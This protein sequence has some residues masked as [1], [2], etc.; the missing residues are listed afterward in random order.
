MVAESGEEAARKLGAQLQEGVTIDSFE[1]L[2]AANMAI[3]SNT[4]QVAGLSV[5]APNED[6]TERCPICF[7]VW[8]HS[9]CTRPG[10]DMDYETWID[11]AADDQLEVWKG[12]RL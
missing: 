3:I 7:L 6:G 4:V 5:F 11:L 12:L 1:P 2:L 8:L 10:C 9:G